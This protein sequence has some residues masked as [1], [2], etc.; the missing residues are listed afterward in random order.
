MEGYSKKN[1]NKITIIIISSIVFLFFLII[2]IFQIYFSFEQ[3]KMANATIS[4]LKANTNLIEKVYLDWWDS[5]LNK[6]SSQGIKD[7]YEIKNTY[8]NLNIIIK[9]SDLI[10]DVILNEIF[11]NG[12]ALFKYN[13]E[14]VDTKDGRSIFKIPLKE[15]GDGKSGNLTK[16]IK[17]YNR[18]DN[19]FCNVEVDSFQFRFNVSKD[20][21]FVYLNFENYIS[22]FYDKE[23]KIESNYSSDNNQNFIYNFGHVNKQVQIPIVNNLKLSVD[24]N[25]RDL[26][27][28]ENT[29]FTLYNRF[30]TPCVTLGINNS[31]DLKIVN[32]YSLSNISSLELKNQIFIPDSYED[33]IFKV[34]KREDGSVDVMNLIDNYSVYFDENSMRT[35]KVY[36]DEKQEQENDENKIN[37]RMYRD[38]RDGSYLFSP[39]KKFYTYKFYNIN[40]NKFLSYN[41]EVNKFVNMDYP[42]KFII[43]KD[44]KLFDL[45]NKVFIKRDK[46]S[47]YVGEDDYEKSDEFRFNNLSSTLF[48]KVDYDEIQDEIVS[49]NY[50]QVMLRNKEMDEFLSVNSK[51]YDATNEILHNDSYLNKPFSYKSGISDLGNFIFEIRPFNS[52][53]TSFNLYSKVKETSLNIDY[54]F[55]NNKL[56]FDKK[57][58]NKV[59]FVLE[60]NDGRD[61]EFKIKDDYGS[62]LAFEESDNFAKVVSNGFWK[63]FFDNGEDFEVFEIYMM[64]FEPLSSINSGF[65]VSFSSKSSNEKTFINKI[66]KDDKVSDSKNIDEYIVIKS[67]DIL[68][69]DGDNFLSEMFLTS[70]YKNL[71]GISKTSIS[72]KKDDYMGY[73]FRIL[74]DI[75]SAN[76]EKFNTK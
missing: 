8:Q 50:I 41:G 73:R 35:Y 65:Y 16:I 23:F 9:D 30:G 51:N 52:E 74:N 12:K 27:F 53:V 7:V 46:N 14:V 66:T 55:L 62:Y 63:R 20:S 5:S 17:I 2:S 19:V 69:L 42:S 70:D 24:N 25:D 57:N 3:S 29:K 58:E 38:L 59:R 11:I 43:S 47:S 36:E 72:K 49:G 54:G 67:K 33:N 40:E 48:K 44:N 45:N 4:N 21:D 22:N 64:D 61:N 6:I 26:F 39:N 28:K 15:F 13:Y 37:F 75:N 76:F 18:Y 71:K 31:G 32:S 34:S 56:I 1:K 60:K 68:F 10:R